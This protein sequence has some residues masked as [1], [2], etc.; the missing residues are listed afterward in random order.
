M[1][2]FKLNINYILLTAFIFLGFGRISAQETTVP[3]DLQVELLAKILSLNKSFDL[4]DASKSINVGILYSSS[5]RQSV[6]T[7]DEIIDQTKGNIIQLKKTKAFIKPIEI[8]N[9]NSL[10]ND[11]H[12]QKIDVLYI[13]PIRGYN[14]TEITHM[15]R[16]SQ[17]L[18]FTG[19]SNFIS[20]NDI[21]VGFDLQNNKLQITINLES[22]KAEGANFSSRL[23]NVSQIK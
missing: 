13:T 1:K 3:V 5:L 9:I 20:D 19:V 2:N 4:D 15:C 7:K 14:I 8:T 12:D 10:K 6:R 11:L 23:L 16:E 18:T 22:A 17:I 21:S